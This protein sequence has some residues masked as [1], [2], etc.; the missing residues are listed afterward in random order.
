MSRTSTK[1]PK[2]LGRPT[3]LSDTARIDRLLDLV[4]NGNHATVACAASGIGE[5]T[6]YGW[7]S[8]ASDAASALAQARA[9]AAAEG[10]PEPHAAQS[11]TAHQAR[12]LEFSE[13]FARARADSEVDDHREHHEGDP[14]RAPHLAQACADRGGDADL[15]RGGQPRVRGGL[16]AAGREVGPG[17][18][19]P[20]RADPVGPS[21]AAAGGGV[22][23]RTARR[24]RWSSRWWCGPVGAAG[25]DAGAALLARLGTWGR[26]T[27]RRSWSRTTS[28]PRRSVCHRRTD[29][30]A[31]VA[32]SPGIA[33][34]SP[35]GTGDHRAASTRRP[36]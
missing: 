35:I 31:V 22:R 32:H 26:W 4:R 8:V 12:C 33:Y 6:L 24:C 9:E 20:L 17:G 1:I 13:R 7:L 10:L 29:L 15:R 19:G 5:S 18:A 21:G 11:I 27:T 16:R 2:R 30:R 36:R 23:R 34:A 25:G 3:G 14:R 28:S